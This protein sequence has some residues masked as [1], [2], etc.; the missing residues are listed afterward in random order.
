VTPVDHSA[1]R[2]AQASYQLDMA[3]GDGDPLACS[4]HG[5]EREL[6]GRVEGDLAAV[7]RAAVDRSEGRMVLRMLVGERPSAAS[8][9]ARSWSVV[10]LI[11]VRRFEPSLGQDA[12]AEHLPVGTYGRGLVRVSGARPDTAR[13]R[14]DQPFLGGFDERDRGGGAE[15]AATDGDLLSC[16][17]ARAAARV[18]KVFR[19]G[20]W[21]RG[22][23]TCAW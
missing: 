6:K 3:T 8:S 18:G 19:I 2:S 16:R 22:D 11:A 21:S 13:C 1:Y 4:A 14:C 20:L 9:S 10:R 17:H 23:H 15:G 7:E 5:G 12:V